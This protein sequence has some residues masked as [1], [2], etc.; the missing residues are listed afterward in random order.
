MKQFAGKLHALGYKPM[1]LVEPDYEMEGY[2][3]LAKDR[4]CPLFAKNYPCDLITHL[5][6][7]LKR[8]GIVDK[9]PI[10]SSHIRRRNIFLSHEKEEWIMF[11]EQNRLTLYSNA[12]IRANLL[13][14]EEIRLLNHWLRFMQYPNR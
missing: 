3:V 14:L 9:Y 1:V 8:K 5:Y 2:L 6:Q 13:S 7:E 4:F 10:M 11:C 12:C